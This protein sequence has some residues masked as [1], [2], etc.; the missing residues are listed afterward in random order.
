VVT[1]SIGTAIARQHTGGK[2]EKIIH[3]ADRALYLAKASG[4]NCVKLFDP[5]DPQSSD[6]SENIAALLR[7]AIEAQLVSLV[8][9]P[10]QHL[11]TNRAEALEAL[12][13]L[14]M[15]DGTSVPASLFIPVA[16]RTGSI[17]ELGNWAIR[18]ACHEVVSQNLTRIVS[19]NVSPVQ[20][21]L[22]GFAESVAAILRETGVA[23][24]RLAFEI[25]EGLE[26][27]MHSDILRCITDLKQLGVEIWLDDFGT[28][29]AGLSW[30]RL[31]DFDI[32]KIDRSFLHD[33]DSDR[34][35]AMFQD[36]VR[37]IRN[38]GP[39]ILVEGVE[40]KEQMELLRRL[41]IEFA[42]GY[43]IGRPTVVD[44]IRPERHAGLRL[45][46]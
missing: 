23:G 44:H 35:V 33:C 29:F 22:P 36:I 9:Q 39:D 46:A 34:G 28:G 32:V 3:E 41:R 38:R 43:Y 30:L 14:K 5:N 4:R 17:I 31:I 8:Y 12:M 27:E 10:I 19:I 37:L 18:T 45:S 42:Q 25:T 2:L 7:M 11:A 16:E 24:N 40:T 1:V 6:D 26:M 21:K 20:L 13:R 15:L